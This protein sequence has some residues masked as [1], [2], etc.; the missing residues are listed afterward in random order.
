MPGRI[1][2]MR[3]DGRRVV[4]LETPLSTLLCVELHYLS[5]GEKRS[6]IVSI[7]RQC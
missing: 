7:S 1:A 6:S 5:S 3:R 2:R 4:A